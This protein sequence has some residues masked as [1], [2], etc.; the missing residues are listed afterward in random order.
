MVTQCCD[1]VL[2]S[3]KLLTQTRQETTE[4]VYT[5]HAVSWLIY[6][7]G[8]FNLQE[9]LENSVPYGPRQSDSGV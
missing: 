5:R 1:S 4:D 3:Y 6:M 7:S 8:V 2:L 9:V